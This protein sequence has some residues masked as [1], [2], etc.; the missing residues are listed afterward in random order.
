M[1]L[2]LN[3][4]IVSDDDKWI[5][6]F[7]GIQS[8]SPADIRQQLDAE[9]GEEVVLEVSSG[10]GDVFAGSEMFY[11]LKQSAKHVTA[12]IVGFAGSAAT[13]VCCGADV[14]RAVPSAQYMIHNVSCTA[15]GDHN[16]MRHQAEVLESAN[17]GIADCYRQ[18]TGMELEALLELMEK[19]TWMSA[20]D[21][22]DYGFVDEIIGEDMNLVASAPLCNMIDNEKLEWFNHAK[23]LIDRE[24]EEHNRKEAEFAALCERLEALR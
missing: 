16:D 13:V 21:A 23:Q 7:M 18:K 11:I 10:G 14:V 12:D 4:T 5:Y 1:A 15:R 17:K 6:D 19:E 24:K 22:K 8:T 3:G 2:K 9:E 20:S